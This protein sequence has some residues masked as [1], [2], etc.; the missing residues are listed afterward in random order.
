M[1][2]DVDS[3][4]NHTVDVLRDLGSTSYV[5]YYVPFFLRRRTIFCPVRSLM[6]G[7]AYLSLMVTPI[8]EGDMPFLAMVTMSSE[9]D[10]GVWATQRGERLLK[11]VRVEL[12]PLPL[13]LHCILPITTTILFNILIIISTT[14]TLQ[15]PQ[16]SSSTSKPLHINPNQH[17]PA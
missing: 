6:L 9:M 13:P 11:G 16:P 14:I 12:I 7:T 15:H 1:T 8:W 4:L 3:L 17:L 10:L 2:S 5:K